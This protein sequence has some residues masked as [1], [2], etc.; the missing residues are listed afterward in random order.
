MPLKALAIELYRAQRSVHA[1]EDRLAGCP[2]GQ[3]DDVRKLLSVARAERDQLRR[4]IEARKDPPPFRR[5]FK[6]R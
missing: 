6:D 1:L 2:L 4:L 3:Q 5:N